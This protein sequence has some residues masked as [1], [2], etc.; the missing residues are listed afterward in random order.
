MEETGTPSISIAVAKDGKIIWEK[1]FGW[2]DIENKVKAT[3]HTMYHLGSLGKVYTATG[4]MLLKER[5]LIDLDAPVNRYLGQE[6]LVAH[7]GDTNGATVRRVLNHTSGL[8]WF[9]VH[10][11]E[12][13]LEQR[14]SWD[15]VINQ[16]GKLVSPPGD[17]YIYSNLGFGILGHVIERISKNPY[18]QFMETE[19]FKPLNLTRTIIDT[20]PMTEDYIAQK[21]TPEGRV[22]YSD[23]IS[24]GGGTHYASA[25]DLVRFG[26]FHLANHLED[27]EPILSDKSIHEMQNSSQSSTPKSYNIIGWHKSMKYGYTMVRHG[28]HVIGAVSNLELIPS[29]NIAVAVLSNGDK[30]NTPLICDWVLSKLLIGYRL[31]KIFPSWGAPK[32][33]RFRPPP[34][35]VGT[36]G[37]YIAISEKNLDVQLII[38]EKGAVRL[39]YL[40]KNLQEERGAVSVKGS[41]LRFRRDILTGNFSLEIPTPFTNRYKHE[42]YIE[43]KYRGNRLSGYISALAMEPMKPHFCL[44]FYMRVEKLEE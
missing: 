8:P 18:H 6:K 17:R 12:N 27:Q 15:E 26:M 29:K 36:W 7:E 3:P 33:N 28:G 1:S 11:Y 22:P 5:G 38:E 19:I 32:V 44:P 39:R 34:P 37:G 24:K 13:E 16:F 20:G 4:I 10:L 23:F 31:M 9:W 21:Y 25:H 14:P 40:N 43:L 30:A 42:A 35:L 41:R 2:A